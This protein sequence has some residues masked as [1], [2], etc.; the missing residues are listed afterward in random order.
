MT[1][2]NNVIRQNIPQG[3][4][5][6]LGHLAS[7][8]GN[9]GGS[10]S[11]TFNIPSCGIEDCDTSVYK[12][13][14]QTIKWSTRSKTGNNQSVDIKKPTVIFATG[15]RFAV[16]KRLRPPR[17]KNQVLI[18]PAISIRRTSLEQTSDDITGRGMNQ[19]TGDLVIKKKL[20]EDDSN[21]Q[22]IINKFA[23]KNLAP[24]ISTERNQGELEHSTAKTQGAFLDPQISNNMFEIYTIPQPQFFTATYE[25][26]FWTSYT[27]HINYMIETLISSMLPQTRGFKLGTDK[28]YWFLGYVDETFNSQD[29]FEDFTEDKRVIRYNFKLSVKGFILAPNGPANMVP[30]RKYISAPMIV[31]ETYETNNTD[32][33][34]TRDADVPPLVNPDGDKFILSDVQN[35]LNVKKESSQQKFLTKKEVLNPITGKKTIKYVKF[36]SSNQKKGE[37][38]YSASDLGTLEEFLIEQTK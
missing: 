24:G 34:R 25:V 9:D 10:V 32:I 12:L 18:L 36:L 11:T 38:A 31:F 28:G 17:D 37:T 7:G 3:S 2:E 8:Y 29:N 5:D 35:T 15:E 26:I 19:F 22:N 30:I 23:F 1:D 4:E 13:F 21:F 33:I 27:Q 16:A 6:D 20:S 14:S